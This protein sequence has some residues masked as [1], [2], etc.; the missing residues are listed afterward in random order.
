M[1]LFWRTV[2]G[3]ILSWCGKQDGRC[4]RKLVISCSLAGRRV[5]QFPVI[6]FFSLLVR[7]GTP[8]HWTVLLTFRIVFPVLVTLI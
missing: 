2:Q 6:S 5:R 8:A 4:V 7:S 1:A 3:Y